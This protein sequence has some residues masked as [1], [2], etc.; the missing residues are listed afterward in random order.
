MARRTAAGR[1]HVVGARGPRVSPKAA[2]PAR[3]VTARAGSSRDSGG[4]VR[5]ACH[6]RQQPVAGEWQLAS[7]GRP[8]EESLLL[9]LFGHC[10]RD[11]TEPAGVA[12]LNLSQHLIRIDAA[13]VRTGPH[14]RHD[15]AIFEQVLIQMPYPR[16]N[17]DSLGR[18]ELLRV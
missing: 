5:A 4:R 9:D 8:S 18:D 3:T 16:G 1:A 10:G 6:R 17:L 2:A 11:L 15:V 14:D 13:T 12:R 7:A